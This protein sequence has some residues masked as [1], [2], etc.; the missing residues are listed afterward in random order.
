M[1]T[2]MVKPPRFIQERI[3]AANSVLAIFASDSR[4][5]TKGSHL[6]VEFPYY[7]K[8][9]AMRWMT[10]G[11]QDFYPV[12]SHKW[13]HG[14]T[15]CMALSQLIRW[16]QGKPVLQIST[17]RYWTG[18][19][20]GI[21]RER[22]PEI[23]ELLESAGY[24]AITPCVLCGLELEFAGDWWSLDGVSGPCCRYTEGCRQKRT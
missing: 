10:R 12:W 19:R 11:G 18:D 21:G 6:A 4:I 15:S 14:G 16:I 9:V 17:W 5:V 7:K 20:V 13:A 1:K 24:P 22:G 8:L 2:A 23:L 3:N